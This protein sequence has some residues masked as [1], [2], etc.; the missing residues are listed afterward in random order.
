MN[1]SPHYNQQKEP[2]QYKSKI[3]KFIHQNME[4]EHRRIYIGKNT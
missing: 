4:T 3:E 1:N 2:K